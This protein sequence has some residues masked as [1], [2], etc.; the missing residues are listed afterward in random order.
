MDAN[1]GT[2]A[3]IAEMLIQSHEGNIRLL[4]ALPAQWH[5]GSVCGLKA[6]GGYELDIKWKNGELLSAEIYSNHAGNVK[7]K[8]KDKEKAVSLNV[9]EKTSLTFNDSL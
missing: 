7:V 6:R 5:T 8:Y 2:T 1:F 9:G 3:G 4:P